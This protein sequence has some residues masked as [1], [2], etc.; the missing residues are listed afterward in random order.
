MIFESRPMMPSFVYITIFG[1]MFV[2]LTEKYKSNMLYIINE[3]ADLKKKFFIFQI[4]I[5]CF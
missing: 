5:Y 1:L 3:K 2:A 4:Q